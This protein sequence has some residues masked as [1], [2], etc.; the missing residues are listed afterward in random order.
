[1]TSRALPT[2]FSRVLYMMLWVPFA[3][4][5]ASDA[6]VGEQLFPILTPIPVATPGAPDAKS[7]TFEFGSHP[8]V[9]ATV[10]HGQQLPMGQLVGAP[11]ARKTGTAFRALDLDMP[12]GS[13]SAATAAAEAPMKPFKPH[14][15]ASA[16]LELNPKDAA[17]PSVG[18][19]KDGGALAP[20]S[21]V[22]ICKVYM[23]RNT[24]GTAYDA[25]TGW[26]ADGTHVVTAGIAVAPG[27]TGKYNV[28]SVKG[29][30]GTVCC[31]DPDSNEVATGGPDSC[32][33]ALSYNITRA[34][35]TT[36]WLS[37]SN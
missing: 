6:H 14:D 13:L 25:Y 8:A 10:S 11:G 18:C 2:S 19:A 35:T 34:V 31:L 9:P 20:A 33:A 32:P 29:R 30:Y 4:M 1:M 3:V 24:A 12:A 7:S 15:S 16:G 23:Y 27:A 36:G 5:A 28:F 26:F 37:K 17:K 22:E 21:E